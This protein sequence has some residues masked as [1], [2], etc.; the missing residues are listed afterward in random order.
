[1]GRNNN[2]ILGIYTIQT[3]LIKMLMV[4]FLKQELFYYQ[5]GYT[6]GRC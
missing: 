4:I 6:V 5:K 1:M 2:L 3:F